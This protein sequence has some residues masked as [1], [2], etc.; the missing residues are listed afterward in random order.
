MSPLAVF[1]GIIMG[2]A[3]TIALG[4][5]M[6]L[7]VFLILSGEHPRLIAEYGTLLRSFGLFFV[8]ALCASSAFVGQLRRHAWRWYAQAAT[9]LAI[10]GIAVYYWPDATR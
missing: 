5:A 8:L 7:V 4:L 9:W 6:V 2:S 1:T 10:A 3:V